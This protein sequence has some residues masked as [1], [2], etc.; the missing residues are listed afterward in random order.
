MNVCNNKN[1]LDKIMLNQKKMQNYDKKFTYTKQRKYYIQS[2]FVVFDTVPP[3][4][5]A[6]SPVH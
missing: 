1:S 2:C 3:H 5:K 4:L 6:I